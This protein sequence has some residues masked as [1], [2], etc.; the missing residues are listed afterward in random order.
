MYRLPHVTRQVL[1][2]PDLLRCMMQFRQGLHIDMFPLRYLAMP[3]TTNSADLFPSEFA[4]MDLA[5]SPWYFQH[6]FGRVLRLV[7]CIPRLLPLV[8][9]HAVYHGIV[10]VVQLLASAYDLRLASAHHHLLDI[11]AFTGS[12]DMFTYLLGVVGPAGMSSYA[13]EWAVENGHL[14][15][16]QYLNEHRLASFDA[17]SVLLAAQ[18]DHVELL[19][20]LLD[21]VKPASVEEAIAIAASQGRKRAVQ[22]LMSRRSS[23]V[24]M[25]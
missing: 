18:W 2:V 15:M 7:E 24:E 12:A 25:T 22:F 17:Q 11:A 9:Y 13:S 5:L 6:G 19:R 8:L 3:L 1:Q 23:D 10:P 14:V 20:Y 21:L 4:N 16:V